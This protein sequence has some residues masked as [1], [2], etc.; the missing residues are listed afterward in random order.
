MAEAEQVVGAV[1]KKVYMHY[2]EGDESLHLTLKMTLPSKWAGHTVD[3]LKEVRTATRYSRWF[4][5]TDTIW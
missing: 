3:Y 1:P 5:V 2:D 4:D